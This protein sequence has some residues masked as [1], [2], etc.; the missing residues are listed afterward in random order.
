MSM[1]TRIYGHSNTDKSPMVD[2]R[3]LDVVP[4]EN[5]GDVSMANEDTASDSE[6]SDVSE[7]VFEQDLEARPP[8]DID[9]SAYFRA[10]DQI[11]SAFGDMH[12]RLKASHEATVNLS[13]DALQHMSALHK[14][15]DELS[16]ARH[17]AETASIQIA[18]L[19][20]RLTQEMDRSAVLE[21]QAQDSERELQSV[22]ARNHELEELLRKMHQG[23]LNAFA[24]KKQF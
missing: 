13:A 20:E 16:S 9:V 14:L 19:T 6:I 3:P 18:E 10:L 22:S 7:G 21:Q 1:L 2:P 11:K 8:S 5:L 4:T 15:E 24:D 12:E 17:D 23:L